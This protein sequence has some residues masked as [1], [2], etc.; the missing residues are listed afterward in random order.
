MITLKC[1]TLKSEHVI[2]LITLG[3]YREKVLVGCIE[4]R[5]HETFLFSF[6]FL[7]FFFLSVG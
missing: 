1:M 4:I 5:F 7:G 3:P 2:Y 6:F